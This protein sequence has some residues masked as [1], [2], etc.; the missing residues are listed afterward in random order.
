M[1]LFLTRSDPP[2]SPNTNELGSKRGRRCHLEHGRG[3]HRRSDWGDRSHGRG[4]RLL[5]ELRQQ[6]PLVLAF[7]ICFVRRS[8]RGRWSVVRVLFVLCQVFTRTYW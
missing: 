8:C 4:L 3:V 1:C 6:Q 2:G 5:Q 7:G